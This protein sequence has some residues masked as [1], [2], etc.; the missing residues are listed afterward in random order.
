MDP[1]TNH[2]ATGAEDV[3]WG[4][5]VWGQ[6]RKNRP[7][8]WSLWVVAALLALA[9]FAPVVA[10]SRPFYWSTD[11]GTR[12]PWLPGLFDRNLYE[13]PVDLFFNVVLVFGVP[14]LLFAGLYARSGRVQALPRRPR[15]RAYARALFTWGLGVSL[16]SAG[17]WFADHR[18][19]YVQYRAEYDDARVKGTAISAVFPPVRIMHRDT[20]FTPLEKPSLEHVLG[21]DES[22]R[23]VAV[24]ILYGTRISLTIGVIA[25]A[26]Y[27][28]I[29]V[30]LGALGGYF[31]GWVDLAVQR[32]VE[33]MMSLPTFFVVLTLVAFIDQPSIFHIMAIIGL[34][35]WTGVA[36]LVRAEFLRLRKLDFVTAAVAL[37][38]PTRR[39]IFEH[40]L[41]NA[42]GPVLVSASFGVAAAILV[43]STLS[44]LGMGDLSAPSWGQTLR[45]GYASGAWHLILA[46]GFAIFITVSA[47]NL[48]GE[49]LR[50]ALD[51]K[52]RR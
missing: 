13:S 30:I 3:T 50:D 37:G 41:P 20:G 17:A 32:L 44:F 6:F 35:G 27:M 31:G 46:P 22:T 29:G 18:A 9:V 38:Y 49:G 2:E 10:S 51:P 23:D 40:V 33:V 1:T 42:L 14:G 47:L 43:E 15:R 34:V 4:D 39:I 24:R 28:L 25:V 5:I 12:W 52:L 8:V 11:G 36:R 48:V 21:V 45:E 7:A 19:P 16:L 26:I